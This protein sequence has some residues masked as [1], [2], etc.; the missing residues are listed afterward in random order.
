MA[1]YMVRGKFLAPDGVRGLIEDGGTVRE[2]AVKKLIEGVGGSLEV[3][4][5]AFGETDAFVICD[6]PSDVSAAA[7]SL[8]VNASG[9]VDVELVQLLT[10]AELD[11]AVKN[12]PAYDAPGPDA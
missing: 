11:A 2:E 10:P 8:V 4:Y 5:F 7:I 9:L 12:I 3:F 6:C 1:K